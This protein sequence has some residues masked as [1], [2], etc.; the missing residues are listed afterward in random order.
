[1]KC[2]WCNKSYCV[3]H[4]EAPLPMKSNLS[5]S[6]TEFPKQ[7]RYTKKN[8]QNRPQSS[9]QTRCTKFEPYPSYKDYISRRNRFDECGNCSRKTNLRRYPEETQQVSEE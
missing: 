3:C 8:H 7:T 5:T 4:D 1:M 6:V 2:P 9:Y